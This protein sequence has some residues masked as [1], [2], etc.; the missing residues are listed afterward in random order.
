MTYRVL[1]GGLRTRLRQ[2]ILCKPMPLRRR[3]NHPHQMPRLRRHRP[4]HHIPH[5]ALSRLNL[6]SILQLTLAI[7][8]P[9]RPHPSQQL[10]IPPHRRLRPGLLRTARRQNLHLLDLPHLNL[11]PVRRPQP[12]RPHVR[13]VQERYT[14]GREGLPPI[15]MHDSEAGEV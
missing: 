5:R 11:H 9:P 10:P 8:Y 7:L 2:G 14:G 4:S 12:R 15:R 3:L 1:K 6:G 13:P